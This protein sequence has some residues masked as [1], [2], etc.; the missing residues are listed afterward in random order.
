MMSDS[1]NYQQRQLVEDFIVSDPNFLGGKPF[2]SGTHFSVEW[3]VTKLLEGYT[4][5]D[6]LTNF[7]LLYA[8]G[9]DAAIAFV[10]TLPPE[11]PLAKLLQQCRLQQASNSAQATGLTTLYEDGE[12][13]QLVREKIE[14][15]MQL[16]DMPPEEAQKLADMTLYPQYW[17]LRPE[18]IKWE[19]SIP[20][21]YGKETG[22]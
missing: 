12:M 22:S 13:A 21:R 1:K 7:S 5:Q 20:S 8:E 10:D 11:H 15:R 18:N 16:L 9:I 19:E 3:V 17:S 2:I 14:A 6:L 4:K